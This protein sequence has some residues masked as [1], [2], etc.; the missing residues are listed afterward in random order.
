MPDVAPFDRHILLA[1]KML[2]RYQRPPVWTNVA[3]RKLLK[4]GVTF[5]S[6]PSFGRRQPVRYFA[7]V[8]TIL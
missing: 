6:H 7:A 3:P 2:T 4:M 5:G 1:G 8:L